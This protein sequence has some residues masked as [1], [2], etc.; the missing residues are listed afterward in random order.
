M[1]I[2]CEIEEGEEIEII[3]PECSGTRENAVEMP[4]GEQIITEC[5]YC[6][7][8]GISTAITGADQIFYQEL[9]ESE[10]VGE[11]EPATRGG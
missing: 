5:K 7:G 11:M 9:D 3:C 2:E 10:I 1:E 6:D 8:T 4:E